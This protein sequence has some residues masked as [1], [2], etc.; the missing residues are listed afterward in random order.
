MASCGTAVVVGPVARM[1]AGVGRFDNVCSVLRPATQRRDVDIDSAAPE[2]YPRSM[3]Y[4][5]MSFDAS[6]RLVETARGVGAPFNGSLAPGM[7]FVLYAGTR[8]RLREAFGFG[9]DVGAD[10]G[11]VLAVPRSSYYR[12]NCH[13]FEDVFAW[14]QQVDGR[15][16]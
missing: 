14:M 6:S 15:E 10:N 8:E 1:D 13:G 11:A 9:G 7:V 2:G 5:V 16:G 3:V 4:C 12:F